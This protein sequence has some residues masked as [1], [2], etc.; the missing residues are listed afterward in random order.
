MSK[1][2]ISRLKIFID[3]FVANYLIKTKFPQSANELE[4]LEPPLE[5]K[6]LYI[7]F[8]KKAPNYQQKTKDFNEGLDK[9][10][11]DGTIKVIMKKYGF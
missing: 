9:L 5:V 3:K 10:Q 7:V 1:N 4:F 11:K 6:P 8:S 2:P